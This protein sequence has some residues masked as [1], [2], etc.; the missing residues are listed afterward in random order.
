MKNTTAL[1][2]LDGFGVN[3]SDFGN[4]IRNAKTPNIDRYFSEYP[5]MQICASGLDV[6]LPEGQM[7][8]SEVGHLNIGAGRI[9]YQPLT[10]ITKEIGEG[11]FFTKKPLL[12]AFRN[13]KENGKKV[14]L[15]GLV[16]D[17]GVH[18][19]MTHIKGLV[20]FAKKEGVNDLYL[21]AFMDGRDTPPM[22]G[23]N[24]LS[25]IDEYMTERGLGK[26][27]TVSGRFYAMD[28]DNRWERVELA[29]RALV[30]G[31]GPAADDVR[32]LM[33]T[34]YDDG[35]TDEFV[36]PTILDKK[37]L[38]E[39]GDSII[40]FNFR[41]DRGREMTRALSQKGFTEFAH[42]EL[43]L[44]YVTM[45]QYDA[46]FERVNVVYP[47]ESI[48]NTMGEYL[49]ANG[50]KQLRIAETEKYAHITFFFNG[51]I[52]EEYEGEDRIL[53]PSPKVETYD[54]QPEMSAYIVT[55]KLVAELKNEKYDFIVVNFANPDMVGHT[56]SF[57]AATKAIEA[58]DKCLG[59]VVDTLLSV[60]GKAIITADH[61]NAETMIEEGTMDPITKH[62]TNPVPVIFAGFDNSIELSE[63]GRLSDL[64]PT[65]LNI[66]GLEVPKEMTGKNL[67]E[68]N[69]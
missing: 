18:S 27:A 5:N 7:G 47:P 35:K 25:E 21:H 11:E 65:L 24:Y 10:R 9:I 63:G 12:D 15:L 58:V 23:I 61:G 33:Q 49:S 57:E 31:N 32:T 66:M 29:Y 22:S 42:E 38:I 17:G 60:G 55:E 14:H 52:E 46:T 26:V 16:S 2:I 34:S 36:I 43:D 53:V 64:A 20:D 39:K 54:L 30:D 8:N 4:A 19:H 62:S 68:R 3:N 48:R 1:I 6:G 41:P 13:A 67:I 50:K 40:F 28:R 44:F 51:G 59:N 37:G 45:S 69:D 56:G